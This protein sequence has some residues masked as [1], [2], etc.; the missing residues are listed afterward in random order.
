MKERFYLII[1]QLKG[2][3]KRIINNFKCYYKKFEVKS[4]MTGHKT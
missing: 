2:R 1:I 3:W 4:F